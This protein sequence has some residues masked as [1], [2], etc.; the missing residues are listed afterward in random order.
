[1]N[2]FKVFNFPFQSNLKLKIERFDAWQQIKNNEFEPGGCCVD[3]DSPK[4][5]CRDCSEGFGKIDWA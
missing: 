5:K 1:M 3:N 4:W 2:G